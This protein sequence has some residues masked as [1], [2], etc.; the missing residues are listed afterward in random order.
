MKIALVTDTY[1]P[2][3]NGVSTAV[4]TLAHDLRALGCEVQICAPEFPDYIDDTPDVHRVPSW[5]L[6]MDPEDRLA[7]PWHRQTAEYFASQKFD[8]VHTQTPFS[9]GMAA[10]RWAR[11]SGARV[12]HT[13]HTRFS[14]YTGSYLGLMPRSVSGR[15]VQ[16]LSK[17]YCN[18][19]DLVVAPSTSIREELLTFQ[20]QTRVEVIPTGIVTAKFR[21]TSP[22]TFRWSYGI[23]PADRCLLFV[24]RLAQEKNID[25]LLQT[26]REIAQRDNRVKLLL[27]GDGPAKYHLR[28]LAQELGISD[29]V[30]FLGYLRGSELAD[31]YAAADLFVFSSMTET[32][33]L[34]VLE[35]LAAGTPV[36]AVGGTGV[37]DTLAAGRGGI[38]TRPDVTEFAAAVESMLTDQRLYERKKSEC[39]DEAEKWSS[40]T[41]SRRMLE[42]YEALG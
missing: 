8:L 11:Q 10:L 4:T 9:L 36:V 24:G 35:A 16:V 39:L 21:H 6:A 42:M 26:L 19:C 7:N 15:V 5:Y 37:S 20:V 13:Y 29:R 23:E 18:A 14:S 34:V 40:A 38:L 31:C 12:V 27:A 25:F 33:G 3:I 1:L 2:R 22:S 30:Q 17:R 41:T 28:E 32:Q